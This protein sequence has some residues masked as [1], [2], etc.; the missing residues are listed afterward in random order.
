MKEV[1]WVVHIAR[2]GEMRNAY[3]ILVGNMK[4]RDLLE[5]LGIQWRWEDYIRMY[6]KEIGWGVWTGCIWLR[7]GTSGGVL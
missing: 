6:F 3:S 5:D 7:I 2:M 1:R 4:G